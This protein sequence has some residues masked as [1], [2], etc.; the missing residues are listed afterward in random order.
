MAFWGETVA[1]H[2]RVPE[3]QTLCLS[4]NGIDGELTTILAQGL[5]HSKALRSL[6]LGD[7][8]MRD[9]GVYALYL[10]PPPVDNQL[11]EMSRR[12]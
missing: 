12:S 7:S 3:L 9:T 11:L 6:H 5:S 10:F 8:N 1:W 4:D 2:R